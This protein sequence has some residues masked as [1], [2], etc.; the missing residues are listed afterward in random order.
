MD[1]V[2]SYGATRTQRNVFGVEVD[3]L[4]GCG[5]TLQDLIQVFSSAWKPGSATLLNQQQNCLLECESQNVCPVLNVVWR[6]LPDGRLVCCVSF[7][8][9]IFFNLSSSRRLRKET[10]S[11]CSKQTDQ[12]SQT[13]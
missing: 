10:T 1:D 8:L 9:V 13:G 4:S 6:L 11:C 12:T 2:F 3:A 5:E 7:F